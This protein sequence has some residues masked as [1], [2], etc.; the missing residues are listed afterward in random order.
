[1][2]KKV[3]QALAGN[4]TASGLLKLFSYEPPKYRIPTIKQRRGRKGK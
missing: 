2:S 1:M 3:G 4:L